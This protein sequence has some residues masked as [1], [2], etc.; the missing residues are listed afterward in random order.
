MT[1]KMY[2]ALTTEQVAHL[3]Q[4]PVKTVRALR[5]RGALTGFNV[6]TPAR[7]IWRYEPR[8]VE[9]FIA[10]RTATPVTR[11]SLSVTAASPPPHVAPQAG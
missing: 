6:G 3:L 5:R 10:A 9:A 7:P 4:V 1:T 2:R 11:P 8:H